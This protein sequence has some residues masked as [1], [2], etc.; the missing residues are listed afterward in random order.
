MVDE[1]AAKKD[2]AGASAAQQEL[3]ALKRRLLS[4][5]KHGE[6]LETYAFRL[7]NGPYMD[8]VEFIMLLALEMP[9][10]VWVVVSI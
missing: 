3:D 9:P 6:A 5:H 1:L 8:D 10:S 4:L 7:R 2:Y